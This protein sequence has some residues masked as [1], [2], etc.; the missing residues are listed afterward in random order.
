MPNYVSGA[1]CRIER[2]D[3]RMLVV[4]TSYR[5]GWVFP[6]GML[7]RGETPAEAAVREVREE[8]GLDVD[9]VGQTM[10]LMDPNLRRIDFVF[11]G[12]VVEGADPDD[13]ALQPAEIAE[14][15]WIHRDDI[16]QL[17]AS[18]RSSIGRLL[19]AIDTGQT[20]LTVK[21]DDVDGPELLPFD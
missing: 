4:R 1:M 17:L 11:T 5:R 10:M 7:D 6:G 8:V 20:L 18:D 9:L 16:D 14:A 15:R 19:D 2:E 3:G 13:L 12:R 21:W